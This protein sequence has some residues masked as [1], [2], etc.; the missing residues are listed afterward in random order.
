MGPS[1]RRRASRRHSRPGRAR[2]A[3][4]D[5][6]RARGRVRPLAG[7][8]RALGRGGLPP[9]GRGSAVDAPAPGGRGRTPRPACRAVDGHR[10]GQVAR[11]P[12]AGPQRGPRGQPRPER[13][14]RDRPLPGTHQGAGGRTSSRRC[15][16]SA[17]RACARP[18]TT[19]TA[20]PT[21]ARWA[22]EYAGLV[23]T[24]PDMLHHALL[25]GHA[26]WS[27]F[28]GP[29]RYVVVD[30][31]HHYRGV[32]GSHVA[33]VLRRLR[34]IVRRATAA[35]RSSCSPPR[36]RP[37][38][39]GPPAPSP[40]STRWSVADDASPRGRTRFALWEPPLARAAA[41]T[42]RRSGGRPPRRP[43]TCS[44]TSSPT[45]RP[46]ARVRAVAPR[47]RGG[48]AGARRMLDEVAPGS[49][50]RVAAYR[51]GYL[52]EERR[53]LEADLR[54][55]RLLGLAAHQRAR[56]RH[57]RRRS[58]RRPHR[59]L[60]GHPRVAVAAGGPRRPAR[61]GRAGGARRPGRPPGHLPG[62][63][64]GGAVR[65][66][67]GGDGARPRQPLR[68]RS[69]PLRR[70]ARSSRS[71]R[72]TCRSSDRR[73]APCSPRSSA[74]G[75]AAPPA[76]RLVL[77]ARG[78]RRRPR[79]PPRHRRRAGADRRAGDRACGRH[80]RRT[81][82][83]TTPHTPA[84]STSTRAGAGWCARSTSTTHVALVEPA[85]GDVRRPRRGRSPTRVARRAASR[86][87]GD[88]RRSTSAASR[89]PHQVVAY[90]TR[91]C[92][93]GDPR[94]R[95]RSTCRPRTLRTTAV[96]WTLPPAADAGGV[97]PADLPGALHAAEHAAIGMLPLFATCDRWDVGG[98]STAAAPRH[99]AAHRVRAT[100]A[101]PGAPGF[102]ERGSGPRSRGCAR[103]AAIAACPC[104]AGCPSCVQSP[105]CG[106]GNEPLDKAAAAA[107]L[108]ALLA[109]AP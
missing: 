89:S 95:R 54:A 6:A 60:P 86:S 29:L 49:A 105:K 17:C 14:R 16:R 35:S 3:R 37:T 15:R 106:N 33:Q 101:H 42:A 21:S 104:E 107:V 1:G 28:L 24:N 31:C 43:P 63:P 44:P 5:P 72:P 13:A 78:A 93:A 2:P 4:A 91:A 48:R 67:G 75:A 98:V 94:A 39:P 90:L 9:G 88:P 103:P 76:G 50:G 77:D 69:A 59:R 25:P 62:A 99:R 66:A 20:R 92:A 100:T 27:S 73:P 52:P 58:R 30:E 26:R 55:G 19:A 108:D 23:L 12:A 53:A 68:A 11:L 51:G 85:D 38:R 32:F 70:G 45:G 22:R 81:T 56:A 34:R 41:R 84:R 80:R 74:R 47:G 82:P 109:G 46:H 61:P 36:R 102:A 71:P 83:A 18:P 57:R 10:L 65:P 8:G 64:P 97:A 7:L 96:W 87:P 79:R 40:V